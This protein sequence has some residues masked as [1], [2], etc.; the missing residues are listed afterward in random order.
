MQWREDVC[1]EVSGVGGRERMKS[2]SV[3]S[4]GVEGRI[5]DVSLN[6]MGEPV[7]EEDPIVLDRVR[8]GCIALSDGC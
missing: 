2:S 1:I 7:V 8:R 5:S 4:V 3:V 6:S